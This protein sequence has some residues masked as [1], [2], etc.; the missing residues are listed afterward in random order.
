MAFFLLKTWTF[1]TMWIRSLS[2]CRIKLSGN[3]KKVHSHRMRRYI[4]VLYN[5]IA[6]NLH[7]KNFH[8]IN[9]HDWKEI[10]KNSKQRTRICNRTFHV[11]VVQGNQRNVPKSVMHDVVLLIKPA[12]IYLC[13]CCRRRHDRLGSITSRC[14][15]KWTH[16]HPPH[17]SS[18]RGR[19]KSG[20]GRRR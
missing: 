4:H 13:H 17:S 16:T 20:P 8:Q 9:V 15:G 5:W 10:I 6:Q 3:T 19:S 7:Q 2:N 11:V 14:S 1:S 18:L 12:G